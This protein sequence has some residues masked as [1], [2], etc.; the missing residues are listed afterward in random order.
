MEG[1]R[2][3]GDNGKEGLSEPETNSP[4]FNRCVGKRKSRSFALLRMTVIAIGSNGSLRR[5]RL[6]IVQ[7]IDLE[8]SQFGHNLLGEE[9]QRVQRLL[10]GQLAKGKLAKKSIRAGIGCDLLNLLGDRLWCAADKR[11]L[12]DGVLHVHQLLPSAA[13]ENRRK[14]GRT[15]G[16]VGARA[17]APLPEILPVIFA[18]GAGLLVVLCHVDFTH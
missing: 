13:V 12:G 18:V 5:V 6:W 10:L 14:S 8:F 1:S 3:L 2:C 9:P 11:A 16:A 4:P 7:R 15:V 17:A